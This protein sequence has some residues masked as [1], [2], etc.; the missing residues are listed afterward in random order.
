MCGKGQGQFCNFQQS[1]TV[2]NIEWAVPLMTHMH[3]A[4]NN[5]NRLNSVKKNLYQLTRTMLEDCSM[6]CPTSTVGCSCTCKSYVKM[7]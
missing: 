7:V 6:V 1:A 5:N 3:R 2:H 4:T